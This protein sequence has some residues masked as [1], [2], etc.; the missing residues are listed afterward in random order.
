M[1][2]LQALAALAATGLVLLA[3]SKQ[4]KRA[5]QTEWMLLSLMVWMHGLRYQLE[6]TRA[7]QLRL[8]F[9]LQVKMGMIPR[10]LPPVPFE[11]L[12]DV[13][14]PDGRD[15]WPLMERVPVDACPSRDSHV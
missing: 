13:L 9:E 2:P 12:M 7:P 11:P 10:I 4:V 15:S 1:A 8:D 3:W 6:Q 5:W 14:I